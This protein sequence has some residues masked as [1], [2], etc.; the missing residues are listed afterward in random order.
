MDEQEAEELGLLAGS[1]G[2]CL[3]NFFTQLRAACP[4]M[5]LPTMDSHIQAVPQ[6]R[7]PSQMTLDCVKFI[8]ITRKD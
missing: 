5:M 3:A 6:L 1:L 2:S 8:E 4:G 7:F